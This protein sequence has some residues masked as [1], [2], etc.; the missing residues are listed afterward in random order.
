MAVAAGAKSITHLV[1]VDTFISGVLIGEYLS[2]RQIDLKRTCVIV[3]RPTHLEWI[4]RC[5]I[6]L[7]YPAKPSSTLLG[8]RRFV[9]YYY[10]AARLIKALLKGNSLRQVLIINNDNLLC[11]HVLRWCETSSGVELLTVAGGLMN[12]QDI[13]AKNRESWRMA[14]K[15]TLARLLGLKWRMPNSHLSAVFEPAVHQLLSFTDKFIVT[16]GK[17]VYVIPFPVVTPAVR[18]DPGTVLYLETYIWH[19]MPEEVFKPFAE[20]FAAW[21]HSLK[22]TR[23]LVKEHPS[24]PG[25]PYLRSLL[26]TYELW[27]AG[28]P[29]ET[30]AAEVP[31]STVVG[32]CS[33]ATVTLK[34]LRP[35]IRCMD[36]GANFYEMIAYFGDSG[37]RQFM[38]SVAIEIH[39]MEEFQRKF[40]HG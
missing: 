6:I 10:R 32:H 31:A 15:S 22:P 7:K 11:N 37:A 14:V 20:A 17:P 19:W 21:V 30:L 18:P 38:E 12:F 39:Q 34:M 23:L 1:F 25:H 28:C 35:D 9:G 13:Q 36:F 26:P 2:Q 27:G 33:T 3:M 8:Q 4:D 16:G 24:F 5:G 40:T 29:M